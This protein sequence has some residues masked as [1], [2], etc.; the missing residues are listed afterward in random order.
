MISYLVYF[1][2]YIWAPWVQTQPLRVGQ[3]ARL[4]ALVELVGWAGVVS[5]Q[6]SPFGIFALVG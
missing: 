3:A 6:H 5:P 1:H 2:G 4:G